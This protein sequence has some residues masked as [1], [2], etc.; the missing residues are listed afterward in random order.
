MSKL[1]FALFLASLT[2]A[3]SSVAQGYAPTTM[4]PYI[5]A[6]FEEGTISYEDGRE[7]K[8]LINIHLVD[9][10]LHK[11]SGDETV[12][13][14]SSGIKS[15]TLANDTFIYV[16]NSLCRLIAKNE[17]VTVVK[18]IKANLEKLNSGTGAYGTT[19][20]T[21]GR[22]EL[23]ATEI[24]GHTITSIGAMKLA[25]SQSQTLPLTSKILVSYNGKT[26]EASQRAIRNLLPD[27]KQAAWKKAVKEADIKWNI[28]SSVAKVI[29]IIP[30][31]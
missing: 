19:L 6:E 4:W 11:Q 31:L 27:D 12:A 1:S 26:V 18:S 7:V 20:T 8:D 30:S 16:N 3:I 13:L 17:S 28:E 2:C 10:D 29:D 5:K 21:S 23:S 24:G 9:G 25:R 15:V 22:T 14:P